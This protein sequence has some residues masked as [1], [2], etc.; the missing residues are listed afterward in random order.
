MLLLKIADAVPTGLRYSRALARSTAMSTEVR[1][2]RCTTGPPLQFKNQSEMHLF[3]ALHQVLPA[4]RRMPSGSRIVASSQV[5]TC[6]HTQLCSAGVRP[7]SWSISLGST[8]DAKAT[9][10]VRFHSAYTSCGRRSARASLLYTP[11]GRSSAT[12]AARIA[13]TNPGKRV[14]QGMW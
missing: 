11:F 8:A 3:S 14:Q 10:A 6:L 12:A 13:F 1:S 2:S 9:Q 7:W 4:A 5:A